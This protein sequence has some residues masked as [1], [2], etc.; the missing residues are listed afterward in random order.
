MARA[1]QSPPPWRPDVGGFFRF[2]QRY[3]RR[4]AEYADTIGGLAG[5]GS[6]EPG[7]WI[8]GYATFLSGLIGDLGDLVLDPA[9]EPPQ[10]DD[11][12]PLYRGKLHRNEG[13]AALR[14]GTIPRQAFES[15][16]GAQPKRTFSEITLTTD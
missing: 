12:V 10:G 14:L 5:K 7:A 15:A 9:R 1:K 4:A 13:A 8:Q 2:Q 16:P 6:V 11:W 3:L